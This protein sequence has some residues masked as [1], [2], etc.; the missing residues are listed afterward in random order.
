VRAREVLSQALTFRVE[1]PALWRVPQ[2]RPA[3]GLTRYR[4]AQQCR[5]L[6]GRGRISESLFGPSQR[7]QWRGV[8]PVSRLIVKKGVDGV[9]KQDAAGRTP[10]TGALRDLLVERT[11]DGFNRTAAAIKA[12]RLFVQGAA[13]LFAIAGGN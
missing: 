3:V 8:M 10:L 12:A 1:T 6:S 5:N 4:S 9:Y 11:R 2:F 13:E 7:W